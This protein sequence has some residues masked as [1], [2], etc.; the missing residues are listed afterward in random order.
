MSTQAFVQFSFKKK[1]YLIHLA[2][3]P[4]IKLFSCTVYIRF[5]V[6]VFFTFLKLCEAVV[7]QI[8]KLSFICYQ[9]FFNFF[10][11]H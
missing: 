11:V 1:K 4:K 7:A 9:Y 6:V 3:Y 10:L 8:S 5:I 2:H